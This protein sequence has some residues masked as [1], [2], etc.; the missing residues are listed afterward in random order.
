MRRRRRITSQNKKPG[1][2]NSD[3]KSP[4]RSSGTPVAKIF[5][6]SV[7]VL[8]IVFGSYYLYNLDWKFDKKPAEHTGE[9]EINGSVESNVFDPAVSSEKPKPP[10][11]EMEVKKT[12]VEILNGCGVNGVAK[13]LSEHLR[14]N[15]FD[16]LNT[17]NYTIKGK[18][19]FDVENTFVI[20]HINNDKESGKLAR[21]LGVP[22]NKIEL[23]EM[24]TPVYDMTVVIG[25]DFREISGFADFSD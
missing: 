12:T 6:Y 10:R 25:K 7:L 24:N 19:Y 15:N 5:F 11:F 16:V 13:I 8:F 4:I 1:F 20:D 9:A 2:G 18:N 17:A 23:K 14:A 3:F 21:V 22:D